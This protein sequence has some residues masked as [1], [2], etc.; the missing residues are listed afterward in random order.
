M[1]LNESELLFKITSFKKSYEATIM[2]NESST[3]SRLNDLEHSS[4]CIPPSLLVPYSVQNGSTE[5]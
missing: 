4:L 5:V 2:W 1:R 3:A